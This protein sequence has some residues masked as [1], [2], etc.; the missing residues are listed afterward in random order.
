MYVALYGIPVLLETRRHLSV[1][2]SG[3]ML[4]IFAGTMTLASP[5]GGRLALSPLRRAPY[6]AATAML[7]VS[8]VLIWLGAHRGLWMTGLALAL[9]GLSFAVSNVV[10]QQMVLE[11]RLPHESGSASALY[12]LMRYVGTIASSVVVGLAFGGPRMLTI[13]YL[14]LMAASVLATGLGLAFPAMRKSSVEAG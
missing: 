9:M 12:S 13:L 14:G 11:V 10:L 8:S 5:L 3:F 1:S 4:L 6:L 2:Q 7:P